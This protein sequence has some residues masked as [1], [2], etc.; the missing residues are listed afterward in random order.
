[1]IP[2]MVSLCRPLCCE[3]DENC[4][5]EAGNVERNKQTMTQKLQM[6][7]TGFTLEQLE[8]LCQEDQIESTMHLLFALNH[9]AKARDRLFFADRQGLYLVKVALLRQAYTQ[10]LLVAQAYIDGREGFG[11]E[12]AFDLAADIASE[13]FLWRLEDLVSRPVSGNESFDERII[14]QLYTRITGKVTINAR[15]V[16]ALETWRVHGYILDHLQE[17]EREARA[18]GQPIPTGKLS[19][20][21]IAPSDLLAIQD[22]RYYDL[23]E[24]GSWDL[25]DSSDLRKLDPEGLSLVAFAYNSSTSHYVFHTPLRMAEAFVPAGRIARLKNMPRTSRE[26]GEY[27][28][29][30]VTEAESLQ[31]PIADIL[32]ELG[33]DVGAI[34]PRRLDDKEH[35][36]DARRNRSTSWFRRDWNEDDDEDDEGEEELDASFWQSINQLPGSGWNHHEEHARQAD[37]CPAC[38]QC[39]GTIPDIARVEHWQYEHARQDLTVGQAKWV[40][41]C[42]LEKQIF[43]QQLPPDYRAAHEHGWGTRYWRAETLRKWLEENRASS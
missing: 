40:V 37:A 12:L 33:V 8:Y 32:C 1:M 11:A 28:G 9:W 4:G 42:A 39:I 26:S 15:D 13:G 16:E 29:R 36:L 30:T 38:G 24:W 6:M 20:L 25:L 19:S 14:R 35:F 41:N 10:G 22:R 31:Q 5:N 23:G 3:I 17:L 21:C 34:C 7:S 43:W 2:G 18:S 27:Y